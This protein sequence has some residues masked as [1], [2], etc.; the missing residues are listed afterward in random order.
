MKPFITIFSLLF[1]VFLQAQVSFRTIVP[2]QPVVAG[3]SFQ[4]QY[5]LEG[6]DRM[7]AIRTPVFA[8][9]RFISGPNIYVGSTATDG[10]A[11]K[12]QNF[13]YTL[14]AVR[15]GRFV[16]PAA[17]IAF[18]NRPLQSN[19]AM[20][21]VI[22]QLDAA[23]NRG[24]KEELL[25]S[26]YFL[27]PGEDPYKKIRE[28]LFLRVQLDRNSCF[29]GE[30]VVATFK[31]YSRLE[32][33]S[34]IVKN[35]GFYGFTV[36]DMAN[37]A[38]IQVSTEKINGRLFD[39][40]TIRKVQLYPL[41][42]GDFIIDAMEVKN[43]VEFSRSRVNKKTEQEIAEGMM[44]GDNDETTG[45][46][47]EIFENSISTTPLL[48]HVKPLPDKTKPLAF[49][50]AA[51][52]FTIASAVVNA[53]L[54]KDEQGVLEIT[55]SGKGNF[56]QL[57][58]PVLQWPGGVE[59][60][61]PVLK[62]DLDKTKV[63]LHGKRTFSFPFV[64]AAPG[65]YKMP[66]VIFS[67]FDTDSNA[68]KT[69]ISNSPEVTVS[70]KEKKIPEIVKPK[71]SFAE[72]NERAARIAGGIAV[73]AVLA[74]IGYW[75]FKKKEPEP[76][77]AVTGQPAM[78]SGEELLKPVYGVLAGGDREFY[79]ALQSAIWLF[80]SQRFGLSGS[81]MNKQALMA[82]MNERLTDKSLSG[83]LLLVLETCEAG[84]F[85]NAA[86]SESKEELLC[87][88]K[89]VLEKTDTALL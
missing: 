30:A 81:E 36:H 67:Y 26:E 14:E 28:N 16:I 27:R 76:A 69:I 72:Q 7:T 53:Q 68:Y 40:H 63:P 34:D 13:V 11:K 77:A 12:V 62:D 20:L 45:E 49:T 31:L 1:S 25:S 83:Q 50:G 9:F 70:N 84:M 54:A 43:K 46:E 33:K 75:I 3:E 39:V 58:A 86:L 61:E 65:S 52:R 71:T 47:T 18:N 89:D 74:I 82:T 21:R 85:T 66:P 10:S 8:G 79:S 87:Q 64:C 41:Q 37:L 29:T 60:F 24:K 5:I 15:P 38:D 51:G 32:S 22:S 2:Q 42:A 19:D 56:T 48:V 59:G 73:A 80:A 55:I 44:A 6:A 35:P 78:P 17:I 88:A 57:D 23:N 4:V